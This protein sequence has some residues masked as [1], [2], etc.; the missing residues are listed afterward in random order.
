MGAGLVVFFDLGAAH[1]T[2]NRILYRCSLHID[3]RLITVP[4]NSAGH[5]RFAAK[6]QIEGQKYE[7]HRQGADGPKKR[8][9]QLMSPAAGVIIYPIGSNKAEYKTN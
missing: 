8:C 5:P 4:G 2:R 7:Y 9:S 3:D 6:E 1:G